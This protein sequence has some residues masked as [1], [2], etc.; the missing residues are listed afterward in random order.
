[1]EGLVDFAVHF[2]CGWSNNGFFP[3]LAGGNIQFLNNYFHFKVTLMLQ[4]V[5]DHLDIFLSKSFPKVAK[6]PLKN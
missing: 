1:M 5:Q 3:Q 4:V 2:V 6:N